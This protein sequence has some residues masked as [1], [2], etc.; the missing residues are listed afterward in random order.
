MKHK[1]KIY[2]TSWGNLKPRRLWYVYCNGCQWEPDTAHEW[3][4]GA[5]RYGRPSQGLALAEGVRHQLTHLRGEARER[6]GSCPPCDDHDELKGL[7]G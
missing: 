2:A 1:L 6:V 4:D 7:N 3:P 5:R